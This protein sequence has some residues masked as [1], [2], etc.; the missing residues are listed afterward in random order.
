MTLSLP[1]TIAYL[2]LTLLT[3]GLSAAQ[4]HEWDSFVPLK[5]TRSEV[6]KILGKPTY[7][8]ETF[9]SY[10]TK[11][12]KYFVWY[13]S[14]NCQKNTDEREWNVSAGILMLVAVRPSRAE[15]I[16]KYL[17]NPDQFARTE[18]PGGYSRFQYSAVDESIIYETIRRP[19]SSEIVSYIS[20]EPGKRYEKL[21]CKSTNQ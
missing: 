1:K 10:E 7:F 17:L 16:E 15:L 12:G 21:L 3:P 13:A 11:N 6:E 20:I 2:M 9:G 4:S 14:G 5:S 19:D 8:S 18:S